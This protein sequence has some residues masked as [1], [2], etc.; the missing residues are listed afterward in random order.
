MSGGVVIAS[1]P[2][3]A[4]RLCAEARWWGFPSIVGRPLGADLHCA[5]WRQL[6]SVWPLKVAS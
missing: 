6:Q 3:S 1:V 5:T 2:V 4:L